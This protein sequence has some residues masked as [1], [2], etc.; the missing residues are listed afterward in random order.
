MVIVL[1]AQQSIQK[2]RPPLGFLIK[3]IGT[4]IGEELALINPL[5]RCL[6]KYFYS[7][8]SLF[9][10]ILYRGLNPS[11]FPSLS[12]ILQLYSQCSANLLA[13]FY[14]N[15]SRYLQQHTSTFIAGL[16]C[17]FSIRAFLILTIVT[18]KIIYLGFLV[19]YTNRVALIIQM[20][21]VL[22]KLRLSLVS[23]MVSY[24]GLGLV[25]G[26]ELVLDLGLGSLNILFIVEYQF[27]QYFYI[28]S[29]SFYLVWGIAVKV[30]LYSYVLFLDSQQTL[31]EILYYWN[32]V[33]FLGQWNLVKFL[34]QQNQV[35]FLGI[36]QTLVEMLDQ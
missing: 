31:V 5:L 7:T 28:L 20:S 33:E 2:R 25:L 23:Y 4:A 11:C 3:I 34:G 27:F 6:F 32:L 35:D 17:F 19:S 14:K 12:I 1:R 26:T 13:S 8:L 18:A 9:Y 16:V 24:L 29:L 22:S 30:S 36:G 10:N 15:T 21:K